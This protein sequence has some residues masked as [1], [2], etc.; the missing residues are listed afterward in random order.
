[1]KFVRGE[2]RQGD[3]ALVRVSG[4]VPDGWVRVNGDVVTLA[5]GEA[6]GH[7]H[8]FGRLDRVALFRPDDSMTLGGLVEV[9]EAST[10]GH[11]EHGALVALTGL[12][13]QPVQVEETPAAIR[14]VQD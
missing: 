14:E 8:S 6:T 2:I 1:M 3:V 13:I 5:L 12:Y 9:Y 4:A 11:Q 7:H 10:L